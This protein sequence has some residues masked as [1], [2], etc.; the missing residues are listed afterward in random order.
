MI[1]GGASSHDADHWFHRSMKASGRKSSQPI[2]NFQMACMMVFASSVTGTKNL[3]GSN[4]VA[5][6]RSTSRFVWPPGRTL[7][8]SIKP[9]LP[10]SH[11]R[12]SVRSTGTESRSILT[13]VRGSSVTATAA[14]EDAHCA[15]LKPA[16]CKAVFILTAT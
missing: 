12:P 13:E 9:S 1:I 4:I 14:L 7:N 5:S 3:S 6:V 10:G 11:V 16:R 8:R 15:S 2:F